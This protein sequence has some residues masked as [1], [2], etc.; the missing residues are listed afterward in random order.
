M[1]KH[2]VRR[3]LP[4]VQGG[5]LVAEVPGVGEGG[6]AAGSQGRGRRGRPRREEGVCGLRLWVAR[7]PIIDFAASTLHLGASDH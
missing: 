7:D 5:R 4:A 3:H 2:Q 1:K 6:Q